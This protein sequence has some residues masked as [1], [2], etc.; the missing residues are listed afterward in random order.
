MSDILKKAIQ[1]AVDG[2]PS[3]FREAINDA[4]LDKIQDAVEIEKHRIAG[5][6]MSDDVVEEEVSVEAEEDLE[7][8]VEIEIDGE[9]DED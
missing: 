4:L 6:F 3:S 8:K 9:E 5:S 2:N 1:S 7:E